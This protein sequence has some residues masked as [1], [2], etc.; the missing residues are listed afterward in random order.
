MAEHADGRAVQGTDRSHLDGSDDLDAGE[1]RRPAAGAPR[2]MALDAL[3]RERHAGARP[4]VGATSSEDDPLLR[5]LAAP[6]ALADGSADRAH[7][8][9]DPAGDRGDARRRAD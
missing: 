8:L 7:R 9:P 6:G 2:R 5:L 4:D 3:P 1:G